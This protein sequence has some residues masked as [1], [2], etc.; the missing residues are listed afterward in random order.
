MSVFQA[1][2]QEAAWKTRLDEMEQERSRLQLAV[3]A[4]EGNMSEVAG[5]KA[6][7]AE[8]LDVTQAGAC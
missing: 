6:R 1:S 7:L 4:L 3:R 8:Q 5:A 2:T